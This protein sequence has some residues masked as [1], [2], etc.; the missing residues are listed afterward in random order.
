MDKICQHIY[1]L[2]LEVGIRDEFTGDI[3]ILTYNP[4]EL[5]GLVIPV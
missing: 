1:I 3:E 4:R 2:L 5:P